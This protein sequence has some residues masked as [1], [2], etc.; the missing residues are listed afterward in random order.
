MVLEKYREEAR[1]DRVCYEESRRD[2]VKILL[3]LP[4]TGEV[5]RGGQK[6]GTR[7]LAT[8]LYITSDQ[9]VRLVSRPAT[10]L[11]GFG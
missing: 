3:N 2:V 8:V 4:E 10:R 5:P 7:R 6:D 9:G 11:G 1:A